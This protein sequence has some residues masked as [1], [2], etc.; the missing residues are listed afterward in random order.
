M[1]FSRAFHIE[2]ISM[3]SSIEIFYAYSSHK[4]YK[5]CLSS[6]IV[7]IFAKSSKLDKQDSKPWKFPRNSCRLLLKFSGALGRRQWISASQWHRV[8]FQPMKTLYFNPM[9]QLI[10]KVRLFCVACRGLK[11]TSSFFVENILKTER[12]KFQECP[13][14]KKGRNWSILRWLGWIS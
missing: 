14:R 4:Y 2:S 5:M 10:L 7:E 1:K 3:F 8:K 11:Y 12:K 13:K 9:K 6:H